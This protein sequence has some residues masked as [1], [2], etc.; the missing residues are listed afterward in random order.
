M[1]WA[2]RAKIGSGGIRGADV[3]VDIGLVDLV[4]EEL[5]DLMIAGVV[6]VGVRVAGRV[7]DSREGSSLFVRSRA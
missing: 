5:D 4:V 1:Y 6:I 7:W 2:V 3:N